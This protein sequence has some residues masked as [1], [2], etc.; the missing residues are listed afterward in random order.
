[1]VSSNTV[2]D[3]RTVI[4]VTC[5]IHFRLAPA[6]G[7]AFF[8]PGLER[9]AAII[10]SLSTLI[11]ATLKPDV[12]PSLAGRMVATSEERAGALAE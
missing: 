3:H 8:A 2:D 4:R 5:G 7:L 11:F 6:F 9:F 10:A 1:V 12:G